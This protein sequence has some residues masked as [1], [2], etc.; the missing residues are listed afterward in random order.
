ME[1][2]GVVFGSW[3]GDMSSLCNFVVLPSTPEQGWDSVLKDPTVSFQI[4][5]NSRSNSC[6][7]FYANEKSSLIKVM[8]D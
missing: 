5:I 4:T 8:S 2:W 1:I 3:V 7:F 6:R